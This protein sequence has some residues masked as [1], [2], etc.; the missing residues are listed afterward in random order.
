MLTTFD[1]DE[2]AFQ[3]LE[4][5]ASGF[6]L[7]RTPADDLIAAI[8]AV[9]QGDE[10]PS[11][12]ETRRLHVVHCPKSHRYLGHREFAFKR[13][14]EL[15]INI[16]I[17][18]DSLA[19]NDSLNLFEELRVLQDAEPWLTAEE[20][21]KAVTV[22]PARALNHENVLGRI[23]PEAYAD[24]ICVPFAN[25]LATVYDEIIHQR[26]PIEWMMIDGKVVT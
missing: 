10:L 6:L 22:N 13:L 21:L 26:Q 4:A 1:F 8:R 25:S 9:A 12:K 18:T 11:P 15:G 2:Y 17:G 3:A 24:M 14:H 20:L 7:K 19:S 16:S 5:G 23:V